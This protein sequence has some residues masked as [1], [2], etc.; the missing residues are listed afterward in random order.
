MSVK[1]SIIIPV[2]NVAP[3][4]SKCMESVS[5][6][7]LQDIEIIAVN[8]AS[9]DNSLEILN[10]YAIV[11]DVIKIINL[12]FNQ[13][14]ANARNE[15]IRVS[16]GKY[17]YFMD[18]DDY[19]VKNDVLNTLFELAEQHFLEGVIFEANVIYE[20]NHLLEWNNLGADIKDNLEEREYS[21]WDCFCGM[22]GRIEGFSPAVWRQFWNRNFMMKNQMFLFDKNTSPVEDLLFSFRM[23]LSAKKMYYFPQK[24]YCYRV[25]LGSSMTQN[26][27]YKR[28][29]AYI[30][31]YIESIRFL[32]KHSENIENFDAIYGY[33]MN[34]RSHISEY[35]ENMN[36]NGL[37]SIN[38]LEKLYEKIF[39]MEKYPFLKRKFSSSEL[40]NLK[41]AQYIVVYGAGKVSKD[42]KRL[43]RDEGFYNFITAVT[44]KK[45]E[46]DSV[47]QIDSL[48][49]RSFLTTVIIAT[50]MRYHKEIKENLRQLGFNNIICLN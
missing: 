47:I 21:G 27:N 9:T 3:Y 22:I 49:N 29:K 38:S 18:S 4:L 37:S 2:F 5:D 7:T 30:N 45:S 41:K 31:C 39:Q 11:Y 23:I 28:Y 44:E 43:L 36:R 15:G 35:N 16:K 42:V 26:Y 24:L 46:N 14:Q 33:L 40:E 12:D 25:R 13:G 10:E 17:I 50:S 8:D 34:I 6:Q 20:N 32:E 48:Q 1:V 19:L